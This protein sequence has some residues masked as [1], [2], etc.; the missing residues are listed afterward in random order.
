MSD[1]AGLVHDLPTSIGKTLGGMTPLLLALPRK[2]FEVAHLFISNGA[3]V[4]ATTEDGLT[5]LALAARTG[6]SDIIVWLFDK[7]VDCEQW[8]DSGHTALM[9]AVRAQS[10]NGVKGLVQLGADVNVV[11]VNKSPG[12]GKLAR[13]TPFTMAMQD[14]GDA[15]TFLLL[16]ADLDVRALLDTD[17]ELIAR[18]RDADC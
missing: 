5:T 6:H 3:D 9:H 13:Q 4:Q 8:D 18:Y 16:E 10:V 2:A 7:G 15:L 12:L 14:E 1:N 11:V 17:P